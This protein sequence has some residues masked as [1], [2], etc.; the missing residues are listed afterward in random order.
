[1]TAKEV[2]VMVMFFKQMNK[3]QEDITSMCRVTLSLKTKT[4]ICQKGL[5]VFNSQWE[6]IPYSSTHLI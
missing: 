3:Q 6:L 5:D 1:M 4:Q 2:D